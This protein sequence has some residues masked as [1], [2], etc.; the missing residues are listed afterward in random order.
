M[1]Y[2]HPSYS[3]SLF[4]QDIMIKLQDL[5]GEVASKGTLCPAEVS[6]TRPDW[7]SWIVAA[8]KRRTL[9]AAYLFDNIVSCGTG[10]PCFIGSELASLPVS[11]SKVLWEARN[12]QAWNTAYNLHLS[13]WNDGEL[14]ISELW[15][16][17][18]ADPAVRQRRIERWLSSVDEFGMMIYAV[19]AVTYGP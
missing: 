2:F 18:E 19:T 5:A 3:T 7:E 4:N 10:L 6:G 13:Q 14:L 8:T 9:F 17:P 1:I 12:R 11:A 15:P 16:Q